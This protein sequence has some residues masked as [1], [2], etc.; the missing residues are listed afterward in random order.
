VFAIGAMLWERCSLQK[1]PP[2]N[3]AQPHRMLRR[4]GIDATWW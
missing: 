3:L 4:A 2:T 1:V